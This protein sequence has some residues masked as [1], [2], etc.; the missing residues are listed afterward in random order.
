MTNIVK[1]INSN[2]IIFWVFLVLFIL[3]IVIWYIYFIWSGQI[4]EY[5]KI[6]FNLTTK[7]NILNIEVLSSDEWYGCSK[8]EDKKDG[9]NI[10]ITVYQKSR[11]IDKKTVRYHSVTLI[12][13]GKY[14]IY[15][16]KPDG[17][18]DFIKEIEYK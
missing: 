11:L 1:I 16:K 3:I 8:I 2:K 9:R 13:K 14:K 12:E 5:N 18:I 17:K 7:N 6:F 4:R 15:Y 10:I